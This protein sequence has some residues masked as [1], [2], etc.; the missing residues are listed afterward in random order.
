MSSI[1]SRSDK[2][3]NKGTVQSISFATEK[4]DIE[5]TVVLDDT[6]PR[7][8]DVITV[9]AHLTGSNPGDL[10]FSVVQRG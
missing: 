9:E 10:D 6:A 5:G 7:Y 8:G 3:G 2:A 4:E 1:W